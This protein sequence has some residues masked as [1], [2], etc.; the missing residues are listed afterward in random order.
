MVEFAD[1]ALLFRIQYWID[2]PSQRLSSLSEIL[3]EIYLGLQKHGISIPFPQRDVWLK[4]DPMG[5]K[6]GFAAATETK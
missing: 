3:E 1:S 5:P 6:V 2:D 4:G